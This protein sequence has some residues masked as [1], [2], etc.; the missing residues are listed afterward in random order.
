MKVNS[1][2]LKMD[3]LTTI[4]VRPGMEVQTIERGTQKSKVFSFYP[5]I[6]VQET[7]QSEKYINGP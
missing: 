2:K 7:F 5:I 6:K 4:S 3:D 1:R